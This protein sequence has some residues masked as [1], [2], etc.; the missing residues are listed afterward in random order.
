MQP[1]K[2]R[3]APASADSP[4]GGAITPCDIKGA[5]RHGG[6]VI[7]VGYQH[8]QATG[9]R[10][11][12][13]GTRTAVGGHCGGPSGGRGVGIGCDQWLTPQRAFQRANL[14]RLPC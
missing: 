7:T 8:R 5:A 1:P 9:G 3:E 4:G 6:M 12:R 10:W 11:T 14:R 2:I 13:S